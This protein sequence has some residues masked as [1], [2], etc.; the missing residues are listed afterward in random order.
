MQFW[1]KLTEPLVTFWEQLRALLP[2]LVLSL[3]IVVVGLLV[4]WVL[5]EVVHRLLRVLRF[6][7][8]ARR[9]GLATAVERVGG[10]RS[11]SLLAAQLV[12]WFVIFVALLI[13]L[14]ALDTSVSRNLVGRFLGYLPN[15]LVAAFILLLGAIISRFLARGVLLACVNAGMRG[16]SVA[17]G[18]VRFLVMALA[19]VAALEHLGL[20]RTTVLVAFGIVFGGVVLA[21]AVAF[22]LGGRDLA[23]DLLEGQLRERRKEEREKEGVQH[24]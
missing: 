8:L 17:A 14:S 16:A 4:G 1:Q 2:Q 10:F 19:A 7:R 9:L 24:L 18:L 23:R 5:G 12:R 20:G 3:A 13:G 22:G 15:L 6:D 11:P 21:L